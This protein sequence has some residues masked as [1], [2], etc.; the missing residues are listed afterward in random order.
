MDKYHSTS[1]DASNL[2]RR[3]Q[4]AMAAER[5]L[6]EIPEDD[7]RVQAVLVELDR[8]EW[9]VWMKQREAPCDALNE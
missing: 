3:W 1:V 7:P 2:E 5:A 9:E 6:A 8:I 4:A